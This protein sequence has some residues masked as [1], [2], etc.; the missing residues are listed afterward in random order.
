MSWRSCCLLCVTQA[1]SRSLWSCREQAPTKGPISEAALGVVLTLG[2]FQRMIS[3][4]CVTPLLVNHMPRFSTSSAQKPERTWPGSLLYERVLDGEKRDI[5]ESEL[6]LVGLRRWDAVLCIVPLL[7][8]PWVY[9]YR[10]FYNSFGLAR[11]AMQVSAAYFRDGW[12]LRNWLLNKS[13]L[14]RRRDCLLL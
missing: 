13:L 12:G 2:D 5:V 10:G 9:G 1:R 7:A 4:S 14:H 3:H 8:I 6:C 11:E